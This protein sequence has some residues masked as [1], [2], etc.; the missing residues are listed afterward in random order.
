MT[1][2]VIFA[3][4]DTKL[5]GMITFPDLAGSDDVPGVVL[6]GGSGPA[7]RHNGGLFD[8]LRA[9]L[10]GAGVA[11]LVYDKRGV[12]RS[13]GAWATATVDELAGDA[14]AAVS[15]LQAQRRVRP[16]RVGVLGH[17]EGGWVALRMCARFAGPRYLIANSC[18]AVPFLD[19]EVFALMAAG[20]DASSAAA[21]YGQLSAAARSGAGLAEAQMILTSYAHH[22][23]YS[24]A[25]GD[26]TLDA[27]T[28]AQLRAWVD[29]DPHADLVR[30][31]TPALA[32]FGDK[33]ALVP[34]AASVAGFEQT[35]YSAARS[36]QVVVFPSSN[37]RIQTPTGAFAAGYL[38]LLSAWCGADPPPGGPRLS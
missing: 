8:A 14:A 32:I 27:D 5:S 36:Q 37:H 11:V 34:V 22:R 2:D 29:Y 30:L 10:V 13:T 3:C 38:D 9:H 31:T 6:I 1:E 26:F 15:V 18:P 12:G 35:A 4:A 28:W 21:L 19:A 25:L 16:E 23:W 24:T 7:D 33:D 17:S 20:A